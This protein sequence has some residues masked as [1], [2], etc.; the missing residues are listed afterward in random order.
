MLSWFRD[1]HMDAYLRAETKGRIGADEVL[2]YDDMKTLGESYTR[3]RIA[4]A[5]R[6]VF[7]H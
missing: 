6:G 5:Y 4:R 2:G 1:E 3:Y 7:E